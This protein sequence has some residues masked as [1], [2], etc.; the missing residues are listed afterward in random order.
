MKAH[1]KFSFMKVDILK[2]TYDEN[3]SCVT[4]HWRITAISGLKSMLMPWK[5]KVWN[6]KDSFKQEAEYVFSF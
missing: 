4:F 2:V 5:I 1:L 6:L 3:E